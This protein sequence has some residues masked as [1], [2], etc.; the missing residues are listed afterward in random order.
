MYLSSRLVAEA[1][2]E[3]G[4]EEV[5]EAKM[6]LAGAKASNS[7]VGQVHLVFG[8]KQLNYNV[9]MYIIMS[10]I[11]FFNELIVKKKICRSRFSPKK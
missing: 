4:R 6:V 7:L 11:S 5:L 3:M 9:C 10:W 1:I 8:E 2:S